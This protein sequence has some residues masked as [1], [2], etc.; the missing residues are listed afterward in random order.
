MT[1]RPSKKNTQGGDLARLARPPA[2][3][4]DGTATPEVAPV[5]AQRVPPHNPGI[6]MDRVPPPKVVV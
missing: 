2:P 6:L 3:D 1:K 4:G 5:G